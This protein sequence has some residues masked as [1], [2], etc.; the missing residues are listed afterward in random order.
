MDEQDDYGAMRQVLTPAVCPL[1]GAR[2]LALHVMPDL[3][4]HR[5]RRS[6]CV[7]VAQELS[8]M[9]ITVP[10]F[11][12][13]KDNRH[14]TRALTAPSGQEISIVTV[15]ALFA[16]IGRIQEETHRFAIYCH[17]KLRSKRL[18]KSEL[19]EIPGVGEKRKAELLKHFKSIAAIKQATLEE[20]EQ[21]IASNAA[22]AVYEHFHKG[23]RTY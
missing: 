21:A 16:L 18:K 10:T 17:K 11:G 23:E 15:P 20:L 22:Q 9:G 4:A 7:G 8:D 2:T 1:F 6:A 5:R 19:D 13:V 3:L 14:R 12:M